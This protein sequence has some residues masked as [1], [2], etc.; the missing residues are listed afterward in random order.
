MGKNIFKNYEKGGKK[1][2]KIFKKWK[3]GGG[4]LLIFIGNMLNLQLL[5]DKYA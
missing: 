2:P 1:T 5:V 4:N 3:G